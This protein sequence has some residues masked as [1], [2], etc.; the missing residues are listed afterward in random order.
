MGV[1]FLLGAAAVLGA[2][3]MYF[4]G[5]D[6]GQRERSAVRRWLAQA[7]REFIKRLQELQY[8]DYETYARILDDIVETYQEVDEIDTDELL[9]FASDMKKH[10]REIKNDIEE[11]KPDGKTKTSTPAT[12]G[13]KKNSKSGV[14]SS[15][16]SYSSKKSSSSSKSGAKSSSSK[17]GSAGTR[18]KAS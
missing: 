9:D 17:T 11:N 1:G 10:Y 3:A 18:K 13:G 12:G 15:Q 5:T 6:E 8:V 2:A 4:Y 7:R 14:R 16:R